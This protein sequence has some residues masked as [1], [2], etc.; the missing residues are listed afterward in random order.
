MQEK[1]VGQVYER[2]VVNGKVVFKKKVG[3]TSNH[4]GKNAILRHLQFK[5]PVKCALD[6][7]LKDHCVHRAD[8]REGSACHQCVEANFC[9]TQLKNSVGSAY[10]FTPAPTKIDRQI[11]KQVYHELKSELREHVREEQRIARYSKR[12]QKQGRV[13]I[14]KKKETSHA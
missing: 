6:G 8:I 3:F 9:M 2:N 10:R 12:R 4:G 7:Y 13:Y 14:P 1:V 11:A 5:N